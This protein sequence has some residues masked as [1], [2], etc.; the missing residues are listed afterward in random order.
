MT[1]KPRR[2]FAAPLIVTAGVAAAV[3]GVTA[4]LVNIFQR[5]QEA[6]NPFYRVVDLN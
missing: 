2:R 5:Q 4:L 3:V 1:E 6:T